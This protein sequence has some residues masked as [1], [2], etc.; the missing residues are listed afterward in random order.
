MFNP[1]YFFLWLAGSVC[2]IS[3]YLFNI[4]NERTPVN[5]VYGAT[6]IPVII[7]LGLTAL[8]YAISR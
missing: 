4:G 6:L 7:T 2:A 3:V 5:E 8:S 1:A